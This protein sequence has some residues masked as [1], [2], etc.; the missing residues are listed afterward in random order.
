MKNWFNFNISQKT[1]LPT[2]YSEVI[3]NS[4][5][6]IHKQLYDHALSIAIIKNIGKY[7][8]VTTG[9]PEFEDDIVRCK[10]NSD[11]VWEFVPSYD[12]L[13]SVECGYVD[14]SNWRIYEDL[15]KPVLFYEPTTVLFISKTIGK[16]NGVLKYSKFKIDL[17]EYWNNEYNVEFLKHIDGIH[18]IDYEYPFNDI[19]EYDYIKAKAKLENRVENKTKWIRFDE[20]S[21][22]DTLKTQ[23]FY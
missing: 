13:E 17:S 18:S 23:D 9:I 1:Y 3:S 21:E 5:E 8:E 6:E 11:N 20:I 16:K 2:P 14:L 10:L 4:S 12:G 22:D 7:F 15:S 19:I